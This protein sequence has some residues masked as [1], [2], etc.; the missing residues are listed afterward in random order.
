MLHMAPVHALIGGTVYFSISTGDLPVNIDQL[1]F[2]PG[3]HTLIVTVLGVNGVNA[4]QVV[5]FMGISEAMLPGTYYILS[6]ERTIVI[7]LFPHN[8]HC[9]NDYEPLVKVF[10]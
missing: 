5:Q 8:K 2:P 3:S 10:S 1:Q 7:I 4:T 6:V 9:M